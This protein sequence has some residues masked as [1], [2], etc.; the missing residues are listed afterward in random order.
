MLLKSNLIWS[1]KKYGLK[2]VWRHTLFVWVHVSTCFGVD[3][4]GG[5][6]VV[7]VKATPRKSSV[8]LI[9]SCHL[10]KILTSKDF[11]FLY[12]TELL[13]LGDSRR[14]RLNKNLVDIISCSTTDRCCYVGKAVWSEFLKVAEADQFNTRLTWYHLCPHY[15]KPTFFI[16]T[17]TSW[18]VE[19][20]THANKVCRHTVMSILSNELFNVYFQYK[21]AKETWDSM[22]LKYTV[23]GML[24]R[25]TSP[26]GN[27]EQ[28]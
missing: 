12:A 17:E 21:E 2:I 19:T 8:E 10:E 9:C 7:R 26:S 27:Y 24:E 14:H 3:E 28:W 1:G 6:E 4:D 13:C 20:W 23:E 22:F 11:N 16:N 25:K 15:L 18:L 5:F